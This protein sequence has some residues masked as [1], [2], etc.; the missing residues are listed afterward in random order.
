ML[1]QTSDGLSYTSFHQIPTVSVLEYWVS[2]E[3]WVSIVLDY[4]N[5]RDYEIQY[6]YQVPR[7][8]VTS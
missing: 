3:Y 5:S 7:V 2:M 6:S 8:P 4:I 1:W